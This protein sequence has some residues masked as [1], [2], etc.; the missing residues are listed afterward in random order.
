[1]D[2]EFV[3]INQFFKYLKLGY[4]K[5]TQQASVKIRHGLISREEGIELVRKYDGKCNEIYMSKLA[6]YLEIPRSELDALIASYRNKDLWHLNNHGEWE[7]K[8]TI[9]RSNDS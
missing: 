6:D 5:V 1:M 8:E 9:Y 3:H 7:L 4:G 2:E